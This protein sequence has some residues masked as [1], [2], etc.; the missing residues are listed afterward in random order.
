[1]LAGFTQGPF[2]YD[3]GDAHESGT[4]HDIDDAGEFLKLNDEL[5][6]QITDWDNEFQSIYN[7]AD[8]RESDFSS[9]E[10][11]RAWIEKGKVLAAR[12][13]QGSPVVSA[14]DYRADGSITK[15][16]CIIR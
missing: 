13:V 7:S 15:G 12:I 9:P 8:P 5:I 1:M 11:E 16:T 6:S 4:N 10:A 14:V 2:Y 3:A